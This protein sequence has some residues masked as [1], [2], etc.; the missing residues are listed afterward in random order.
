MKKT[1]LG[2]ATIALITF[3]CGD[4]N[5]KTD[6]EFE[7]T[8]AEV[9]DEIMGTDNQDNTISL[10]DG[11]SMD[12]WRG[13]LS[14]KMYDEWTIDGDA[15]MFTP[16]SE[17]GKNII[18]KDTFTNFVLKLDWKV[19]EGANSGIFYGVHEDKKFPEAYQTGPE[20][21]VLDNERHP[22]A[23]VAGGTHKAGSLYDMIAC[24]PELINPAGE[25]NNMELSV[26]HV[27]NMGQVY[28]NGN[29]AFTFTV[30]GPEWDRMVAN[31]KF[32]GWE[33]FGKYQTGHIGLQDHGNKVWFKNISITRL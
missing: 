25:W 10:F 9:E 24:P 17:G 11:K 29:L 21:Q 1:L 7:E 30:H 12:Q 2:L 31:S 27:D 6:E 4:K 15:M 19:E 14:D 3:S 20:I 23:K 13:Y 8:V 16:G 26:N 28:M 22:D 18:T 33:G 5:E 32:K